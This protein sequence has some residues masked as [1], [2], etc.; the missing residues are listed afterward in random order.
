MRLKLL[1]FSLVLLALP[2]LGWRYLDAM[3]GFLLDGQRQAQALTAR[4][5][6]IAMA[7][8]PDEFIDGDAR[9]GDDDGL[10][11]YA[12][13]LAEFP[14]LDGHGGDWG[15]LMDSLQP[16]TGTPGSDGP[17]LRWIAATW[18]RDLFMLVRVR[19]REGVYCLPCF[20]SL[21]TSDHL[22]LRLVN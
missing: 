9:D 18:G 15:S 8:Y 17:P 7:V 1:L 16:V 20:P 13:P 4:A 10:L 5:L 3:Q 14:L 21:D 22:R 11:R 2:W 12:R 6:A 19:D